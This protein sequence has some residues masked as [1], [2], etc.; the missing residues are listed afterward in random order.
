[1]RPNTEMDTAISTRTTYKLRLLRAGEA[2]AVR[3][4]ILMDMRLRYKLEA[5]V[6]VLLPI[7]SCH[8]TDLCEL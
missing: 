1:M 8:W 5:E 3:S 7:T 2:L 6:M 4:S